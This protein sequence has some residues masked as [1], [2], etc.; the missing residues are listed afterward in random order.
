MLGANPYASNGSLATAPDWP[1]RIEALIARGGTL[2]VVDPRRT[3][4]AEEADAARRHPA[5]APTPSCSWRW[6]T[7]STPRASSTPA[8][9]ASTWRASTR[10]WPP[11]APFTPEAVAGGDRRRRR[12]ASAR[13]PTTWPPPPSACVYGRI[14]TTT[15]AVRHAHVVA[16]RRAQRAAPATS[17]GPAAPCSPRRR[18][19]PP[20]PGARPAYGRG[21]QARPPAQP[22][23]GRCPRR[24]ASCRSPAWPRRSTRPATAR[25]GRW[26][27]WPATRCCRPRT[28]AGSTPP[29]P[30]STSTWRS[31][32]T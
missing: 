14:G 1:G 8:R 4:T 30:R 3:R 5:R 21:V 18:P 27:P 29:S 16:G 26:S 11:L 9:R 22:G 6:S 20:T 10:C 23:P 17:T 12:D 15:A 19:A 31:T 24:W 25:S 28:R 13:W 32:P 2:V 7:C